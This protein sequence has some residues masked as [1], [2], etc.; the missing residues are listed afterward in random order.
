MRRTAR[1]DGLIAKKRELLDR[2]AEKRQALITRAVTKGLNPDAPLRPSDMGARS[3]DRRAVEGAGAMKPRSG[4]LRYFGR[5]KNGTTPAS[6][7][8]EYWD[9]DVPWATPEDLGKL[10]GD[11]ISQTKRQ[12]H[13]ECSRGEQSLSATRRIS[14]HLNASANRAYGHQ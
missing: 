1:I 11:R 8:A 12:V 3:G 7:E 14:D 9:G 5:I 6:G 4:P 10:A 2:L 13:G